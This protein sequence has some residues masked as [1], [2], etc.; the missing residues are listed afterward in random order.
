[1]AENPLTKL[2][3]LVGGAAMLPGPLGY[4]VLGQLLI[5][6]STGTELAG[7]NVVLAGVSR[8]TNAAVQI[9]VRSMVPAVLV[10]VLSR[11]EQQRIKRLAS[12]L[13]HLLKDMERRSAEVRCKPGRTNKDQQ[14][15]EKAQSLD[16][17]LLSALFMLRYQGGP[18][19]R[20]VNVRQYLLGKYD[21]VPIDD[22]DEDSCAE[23]DDLSL[24]KESAGLADVKRSRK[25]G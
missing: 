16:E 14:K 3:R 9:A 6:R 5:S 8:Q 13:E 18:S 22:G 24:P 19:D 4:Q 23:S 7:A 2:A 25:G 10:E 12:E 20:Q 11:K 17:A 21:T 15:H 1:M